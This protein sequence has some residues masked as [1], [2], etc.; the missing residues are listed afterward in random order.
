M[1]GTRA[2][3]SLS[4]FVI[5]VQGNPVEHLPSFLR[6]IQSSSDWRQTGLVA[7]SFALGHLSFA[8]DECSGLLSVACSRGYHRSVST[9]LLVGLAL[10]ELKVAEAW[11]LCP[12][13]YGFLGCIVCRFCFLGSRTVFPHAVFSKVSNLLIFQP[14]L[15]TQASR[16]LQPPREHVRSAR[17]AC[18]ERLSC[19]CQ[20]TH[21]VDGWPPGHLE[22]F[23]SCALFFG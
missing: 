23:M 8:P 21:R 22:A 15:S 3:E 5:F 20:R 18:R 4:M 13:Y 2:G 12:S 6:I 16:A 1:F 11:I 17:S 19:V 14:M 9:A 10:R 7:L